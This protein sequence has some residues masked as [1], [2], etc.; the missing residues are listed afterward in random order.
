MGTIINAT[1]QRMHRHGTIE[2][3]SWAMGISVRLRGHMI[4]GPQTAACSLALSCNLI[5]VKL[6]S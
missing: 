5:T 3:I 6:T 1:A 4:K 2:I